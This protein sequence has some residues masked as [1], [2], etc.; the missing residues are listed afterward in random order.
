MLLVF[1]E[2]EGLS[3]IDQVS[4]HLADVGQPIGIMA[5]LSKLSGIRRSISGGGNP[6]LTGAS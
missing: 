5:K 1:D 3:G 4:A 6:R 2:L